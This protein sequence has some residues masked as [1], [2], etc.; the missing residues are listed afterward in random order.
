VISDPR[1]V[2]YLV[3]TDR[4]APC[5]L[6]RVRWPDV[7]QAVSVGSAEWLDDPGLF[8]LPYN[9][10]SV[11]VSFPQ[12]VSVA[13]AFG[14]QLR[15][16]PTRGVPSFMR[17]MPSNWSDLS[18]AERRAF[19][20]ESGPRR[21]PPAR[22]LRHLQ[23][24]QARAMAAT[25]ASRSPQYASAPA[26]PAVGAGLSERS[27]NGQ[28]DRRLA[29]S[30]SATPDPRRHLRLDVSGRALIRSGTATMTVGLVDLSEGGVRCV[31]PEASPRLRPGVLDGPF[32]LEAQGA[33][34]LICLDV[35]GKVVWQRSI[36]AS[37]HFGVVFGALSRGETEGIRSFLAAAGSVRGAR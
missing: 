14:V 23:S 7:S 28:A 22:R 1:G 2:K 37:T 4:A 5:L 36:G 9:P 34:S 24:A 16:E 25:A 17:R 10:D 31:Q 30:R 33:T 29:R 26:G 18:P 32:L 8:D 15:A 27:G 6:A 19:G 11:R 21:R 20:L 12:A 35:P 13:A 3:L